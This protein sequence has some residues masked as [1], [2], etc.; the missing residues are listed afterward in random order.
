MQGEAQRCHERGMNAN[1]F[2]P[3]RIN[4]LAPMLN[5]WLPQPDFAANPQPPAGVSELTAATL[6][7]ENGSAL[8]TTQ[9]IWNPNTLTDL[10]GDNPS[11]HKRLL[12]K[13][14]RNSEKQVADMLAASVVDD[15]KALA[16]IAHTLKSAARSV[17]ALAL[18]ELCQ[19]LESAGLTGNTRTCS[20]FRLPD[21][22]G[23]P[24]GTD[25][26]L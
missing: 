2:K 5:K 4:E 12:K 6:T 21:P 19:S 26:V 13:F 16:G 11:M 17:G 14:L 15:L 3:F 23:I 1:L 20:N 7:G 22:Q 18:G 24:N 10:I 25:R 9:P 8:N